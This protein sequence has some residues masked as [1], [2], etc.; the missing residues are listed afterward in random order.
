VKNEKTRSKRLNEAR[1]EKSK[2]RKSVEEKLSS[3][4]GINHDEKR[5]TTQL[6]KISEKLN[7]MCLTF[8]KRN[9]DKLNFV[10]KFI[11]N[12]IFLYYSLDDE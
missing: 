8:Y 6:E 11:L 7:D 5:N 2:K 3:L 12:L 10:R 1:E 4:K 9:S